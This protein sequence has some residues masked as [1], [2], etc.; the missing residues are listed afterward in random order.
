[1]PKTVSV[2]IDNSEHRQKVAYVEILGRTLSG[3]APW[4]QLEGGDPQE[5]ALRNQ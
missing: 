2:H 1:M 4:L 5:V 3:I